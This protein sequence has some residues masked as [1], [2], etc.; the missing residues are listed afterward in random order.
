M[1]SVRRKAELDRLTVVI[2][3]NGELKQGP[4]DVGTK[5]RHNGT[6][7]HAAGSGPDVRHQSARR[8]V[9][10]PNPNESRHGH[11]VRVLTRVESRR[12]GWR[13]D[14]G[15]GRIQQL[16]PCLLLHVL[17]MLLPK[18][19][20]HPTHLWCRKLLPLLLLC[21]VLGPRLQLPCI[22]CTLSKRLST[23]NSLLG[24]RMKAFPKQ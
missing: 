14:E 23:G 19:L 22:A 16:L 7:F 17:L 11:C 15:R 8:L 4:S 21:E 9:D 10:A 13:W 12:R 2:R 18:G 6:V 1:D 24:Q 5:G 3:I 20:V